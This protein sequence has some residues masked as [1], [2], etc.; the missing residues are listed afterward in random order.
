VR[1][2]RISAGTRRL[3]RAKLTTTRPG[4]SKAP[5]SRR[6]VGYGRLEGIAAVE[7]LLRLDSA[8]RLFVNFFQPWFNLAEKERIG[9]HVRNRYYAP[10]T[11][12]ARLVDRTP[13]QPLL[14]SS[15]RGALEMPATD[16][17]ECW[18]SSPPII[19]GRL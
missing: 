10:E 16:E 8:S 5:W 18:S 17:H 6:L 11:P 9:S 19:T 1:S 2:V 7:A 12:C 13:A 15:V 3:R 14:D 4:S